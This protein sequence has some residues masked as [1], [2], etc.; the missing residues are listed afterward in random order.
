VV[1]GYYDM[2]GQDDCD[3]WVFEID[4]RG[5][6]I[7]EQK[8]GGTLNDQARFIR[9]TADD[10]YIVSGH[11]TTDK[12]GSKDF[13]LAKLDLKGDTLWTTTF[14]GDGDDSASDLIQTNDGGFLMVGYTRSYSQGDLD[15]LLLKTDPDGKYEWSEKFGGAG[16]DFANHIEKGKN[17][18]YIISGYSTMTNG[19][20]EDVLI[21]KI[22][23][24]GNGL[25]HKLFGGRGYD[26]GQGL[27]P[28]SDGGFVCVAITNSFGS[29][30]LDVWML[31]FDT[32]H[33]FCADF[34]ADTTS[35]TA[36]LTVNFKDLSQSSDTLGIKYWE[37]DFDGDGNIDSEIQNPSW[38]YQECG[39][40]SVSLSSGNDRL[41]DSITK[42][43]YVV[44]RDNEPV[45]VNVSDIPDD[46][47]GWV[48]ISFLGSIF[49][50]DT[51]KYKE[52]GLDSHA[53]ELYTV[54]LYYAGKW[55]SANSA[56]AY[57]K[58]LY[59]VLVHTPVDSSD[60]G[61]GIL[62]F[63]VI[64]AM[65]EGIFASKS[66]DGYSVDNIIPPVPQKVQ[67]IPF[68]QVSIRLSWDAVVIDDLRCYRVYRD[69]TDYPNSS[70]LLA[71]TNELEY[72]DQQI[73]F[74]M[75]YTYYL[76]SVDIHGNESV[77]SEL[78]EMMLNDLEDKEGRIPDHFELEQNYPNPFNPATTIRYSLP[79]VSYVKIVILD[80]LGNQVRTL[81]DNEKGIGSHSVSWDGN[82]D[83]GNPVSSGQYFYMMNAGNFIQKLKMLL[84]R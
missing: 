10:C 49:D 14:G 22:H 18:Q 73:S 62:Q 25:E 81:V 77:R 39:I 27:S 24:D 45:I 2:P 30:N 6:K 69:K 57:G 26:I 51:I 44:V 52:K 56:G 46:Q 83:K 36:P 80:V 29:G 34:T 33:T 4:D 48:C 55:I 8:F 31:K 71:E 60:Y 59:S 11:L 58:N 9:H 32:I 20:D 75:R 84:I 12:T 37:W 23:E 82:N 38:T 66:A 72:I 3:F 13:L 64:A 43:D 67:G 15:A 35:G 50:T 70:L 21:L 63:R 16:N 1:T 78:V 42:K 61:D 7:W 79:E 74:N 19:G 40:Y 41:S 65:N 76:T 47:G 54:E 5:N 17:E 53:P 28:T 68:D